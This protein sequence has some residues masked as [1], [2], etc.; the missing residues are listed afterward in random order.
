M[1]NEFRYQFATDVLNN[2]TA[3][4]YN[5]IKGDPIKLK[6][7]DDQWEKLGLVITDWDIFPYRKL[8]NQM[9]FSIFQ[10]KFQ[11]Y[12]IEIDESSKAEA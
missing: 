12:N 11:I 1:P 6:I 10:I 7:E 3:I 8:A 4:Y 9:K 5:P 2:I